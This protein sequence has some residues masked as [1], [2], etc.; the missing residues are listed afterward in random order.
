MKPQW[1]SKPEAC[2]PLKPCLEIELR[3]QVV[4]QALSD[5]LFGQALGKAR[6]CGDPSRESGD[7][8]REG[9]IVEYLEDKA[10][11]LRLVSGNGLGGEHEGQRL[12][13]ADETRQ[14]PGAARIGHQSD[15]GEALLQIGGA[16][17]HDDIAGK[18]DVHGSA[19][20]RPVEGRDGDLGIVGEL[21]DQGI[22]I[23]GERRPEVDAALLVPL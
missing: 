8:D 13:G 21:Q 10:H 4:R 1:P 15:L 2:L 17:G 7:I 5:G 12:L 16:R 18:R 9:C 11:A 20:R 3:S 23:A 14:D 22:V 19:H 6:A